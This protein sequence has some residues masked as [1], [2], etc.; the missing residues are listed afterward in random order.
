MLFYVGSSRVAAQPRP[1]CRA[2][3]PLRARGAP[4]RPSRHATRRRRRGDRRGAAATRTPPRAPRLSSCRLLPRLGGSRPSTTSRCAR[5][6]CST[7]TRGS[8]ARRASFSACQDTLY[9]S[10]SVVSGNF[11]RSPRFY[12]GAMARATRRRATDWTL[13]RRSR[14][15][16][17]A[18]SQRLVRDE[19]AAA[20]DVLDEE[21]HRLGRRRL[22]HRDHLLV[23]RGV[24][25]RRRRCGAAPP[26]PPP[27]AARARCRRRRAACRPSAPPRTA[28]PGCRS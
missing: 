16:C 17:G 27:D 15:A 4:S 24:A 7:R 28:R 9:D 8:R 21:G 2:P 23:A 14:G 18:S 6:R 10:S 12:L 25:A 26:P 19:R 5:T 3:A 22:L 11:C 20:V 1:G 13:V